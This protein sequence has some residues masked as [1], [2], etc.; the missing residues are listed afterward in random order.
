MA[1]AA[2]AFNHTYED[3][4]KELGF[5]LTSWK[6]KVAVLSSMF[7]VGF[8]GNMTIFIMLL[9]KRLAVSQAIRQLILNLL[10]ADLFVVNFCILTLAIWHYT[11]EWLAGDFMCRFS[12]FMQMFSLYA[13]TFIIVVISLDRCIAIAS[14]L[15]AMG[16]KVVN[17]RMITTAWILAGL[18]SIPQAVIFKVERAPIEEEFYQCVTFGSY[19]APWQE[20][21]YTTFTL[22]VNFIIPLVT[23]VLCYALILYKL[24][25][26]GR[27]LAVDES[28]RKG[29][30]SSCLKDYP[31]LSN[32][33]QIHYS[34]NPSL[35]LRYAKL[36]KAR[37]TSFWISMLI[38]M[39]FVVCWGPYYVRMVG[40]FLWEKTTDEHV[41][42]F[43]FFF[44]MSN[45]VINPLIYG[46]FHILGR[47]RRISRQQRSSQ[48]RHRP[49]IKEVLHN[50]GPG[51]GLA[52]PSF[53]LS[54]HHPRNLTPPKTRFTTC[55]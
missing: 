51:G 33:Q 42:N 55:V 18:F 38:V 50:G 12:K 5:D 37:T 32:G 28:C 44:G 23:I 53:L 35:T 30:T 26:G 29:S 6:I 22:F 49:A 13:S 20:A 46:A 36:R 41:D 9:R 15:G 34:W 25:A 2:V 7:I 11:V 19:T 45:S 31:A 39:A 8:A 17:Q 3:S 27:L 47:S 54:R 10:I 14:P 21:V 52:S 48:G 16:K 24:F 40:S 1:A 43:V 4:I